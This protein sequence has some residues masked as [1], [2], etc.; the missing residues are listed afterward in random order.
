MSHMFYH[1]NDKN[2]LHC[3]LEHDN[4]CSAAYTGHL[5]EFGPYSHA[6]LYDIAT[7]W[8]KGPEM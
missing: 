3:W 1:F 6:G 2:F 7:T 4:Q 5:P 8:E